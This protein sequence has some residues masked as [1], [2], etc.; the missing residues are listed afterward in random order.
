MYINLLKLTEAV[1]CYTEVKLTWII[2]LP[3]SEC[4]ANYLFRHCNNFMISH[5]NFR[6]FHLIVKFL[7]LMLFSKLQQAIFNMRMVLY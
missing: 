2:L 7:E 3:F 4:I 1:F 6:I 5:N